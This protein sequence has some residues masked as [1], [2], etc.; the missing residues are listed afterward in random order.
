MTYVWEPLDGAKCQT[1]VVLP[2]LC[3]T[4]NVFGV[5]SGFF[6]GDPPPV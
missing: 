3:L 2:E 1:I 4:P 5:R 6:S